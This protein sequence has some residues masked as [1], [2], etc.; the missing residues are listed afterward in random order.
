MTGKEFERGP[1]RLDTIGPIIAAYQP[2]RRM[3]GLVEEGQRDLRRAGIGDPRNGLV[4]APVEG[5]GQRGRNTG[6]TP[7]ISTAPSISGRTRS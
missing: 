7:S 1:V 2:L 3:N 6:A 4:A 5:L